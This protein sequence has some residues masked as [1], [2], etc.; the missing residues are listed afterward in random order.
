[1]NARQSIAPDPVLAALAEAKHAAGGLPGWVIRLSDVE[2]AA[3]RAA[4]AEM[5]KELEAAIE[6]AKQLRYFAEESAKL[7]IRY[8]AYRAARQG[9]P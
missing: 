4:H 3:A 5:G 7:A 9:K 6:D 8:A 1:M 2:Y